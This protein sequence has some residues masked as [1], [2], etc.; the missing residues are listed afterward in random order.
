MAGL[1]QEEKSLMMNITIV[2]DKFKNSKIK[3]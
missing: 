1:R 3:I 2:S